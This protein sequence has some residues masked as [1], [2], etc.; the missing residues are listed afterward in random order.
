M[1]DVIKNAVANM[2]SRIAKVPE[3]VLVKYKTPIT[4]ALNILMTLSAVP[5]FFFIFLFFCEVN[6]YFRIGS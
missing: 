4:T 5:I 6:K 2:P 1:N 3:M